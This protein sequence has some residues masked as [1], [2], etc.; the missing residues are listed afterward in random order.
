MMISVEEA[1]KLVGENTPRMSAAKV[2]LSDALGCVVSED[3]LSPV[4]FPPFAQSAMDGYAVNRKVVTVFA[5]NHIKWR[6]LFFKIKP[7]P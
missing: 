6:S 1:I 2:G 4:T 7:T 3:I 5:F